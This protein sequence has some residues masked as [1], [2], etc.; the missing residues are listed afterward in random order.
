M[1][2]VKMVQVSQYKWKIVSDRGI[3]L[4]EPIYIASIKAEEYIKAYISSYQGWGYE[5]K[6]LR[7]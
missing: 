1:I 3:V 4:Q 5:V 2:V 6:P 7:K